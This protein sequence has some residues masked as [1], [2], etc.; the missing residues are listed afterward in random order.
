MLD[1]PLLYHAIHALSKSSVR[2]RNIHIDHKLPQKRNPYGF[3]RKLGC[4]KHTLC[5]IA[6]YESKPARRSLQK[7]MEP[8]PIT[9]GFVRAAAIYA[10]ATFVSTMTISQIWRCTEPMTALTAR[11]P[12][13]V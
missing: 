11:L 8:S 1:L 2:S 13:A 6:T 4:K 3:S 9:T 7:G 12:E 5:A 10:I